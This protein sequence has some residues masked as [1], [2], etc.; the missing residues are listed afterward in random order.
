MTSFIVSKQ[1]LLDLDEIWFYIANDNP[2]VA[3]KVEDEIKTKF[4]LLAENPFIGHSHPGFNHKHLRCIGVYSYLI[5]YHPEAK[6][7]EIIRVLSGY[8][9]MAVAMQE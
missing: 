9:D 5:I 6:P 1:A 4:Q 3:N 8:R 7:L 2:H